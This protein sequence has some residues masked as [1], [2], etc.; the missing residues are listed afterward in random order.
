MKTPRPNEPKRRP[1][2]ARYRRLA[3][4][5]SVVIRSRRVRSKPP[6]DSLAVVL[7]DKVND[8]RASTGHASPNG[9]SVQPPATDLRKLTE[10][11]VPTSAP[12][13]RRRTAR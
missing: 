6:G 11:P 10:H 8:Q 7:L 9:S 5:T 4:T 3:L 2:T 1:G 13:R 12:R